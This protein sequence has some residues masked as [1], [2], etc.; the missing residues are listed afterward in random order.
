MNI[1]ILDISVILLLEDLPLDNEMWLRNIVSVNDC[2]A[3][4]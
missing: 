3:L 1:S 4:E 2:E